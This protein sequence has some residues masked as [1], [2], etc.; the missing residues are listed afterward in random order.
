MFAFE[1]LARCEGASLLKTE[2]EIVYDDSSGK[3]TD[4]LVQI[5]TSKVGVSV[6]RATSFPFDATYPQGTADTIMAGKLNDIVLSSANVSAA[7]AWVKQVLVVM[8]YSDDHAD[9]IETAWNNLAAPTKANTVVYVVVTDG[10]DMPVYASASARQNR[11]SCASSAR[12]RE[13]TAPA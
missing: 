11:T 4:L 2:S 12:C 8:A 1:T 10:S 3:K 13:T 7:D 9:K 6:V 5:G